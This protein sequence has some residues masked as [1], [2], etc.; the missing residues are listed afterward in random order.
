MSTIP[1]TCV[2]SGALTIVGSLLFAAAVVTAPHS[3]ATEGIYLEEVRAKV[4]APVTDTQAIQL[5]NIA[6]A[7]LR[8]GVEKGLTFGKARH[9]ADQAVGYASQQLG[10]GLSMP[11]GMFLVEAAEGQLC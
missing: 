9:E 10:L 3:V 4:T 1:V 2:R 11:D 7:A 5:G 8:A 6:C